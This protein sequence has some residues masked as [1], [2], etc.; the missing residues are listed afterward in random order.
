MVILH[1]G[2]VGTKPS[3]YGREGSY[4]GIEEYAH[5]KYV[6]MAGAQF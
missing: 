4:Y 2:S 1:S 3:G 6:R 5:V